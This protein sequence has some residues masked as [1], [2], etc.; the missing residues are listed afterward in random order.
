MHDKENI[1]DSLVKSV[2]QNLHNINL[3]LHWSQGFPLYTK[4]F[5]Q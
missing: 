1:F 3:A 4:L 2:L 5:K